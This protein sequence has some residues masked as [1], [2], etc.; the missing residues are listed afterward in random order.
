M[1]NFTFSLLAPN[2]YL[3]MPDGCMD[4][5]TLKNIVTDKMVALKRRHEN[6]M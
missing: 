2:N 5:V 4:G 6:T 3:I 1:E